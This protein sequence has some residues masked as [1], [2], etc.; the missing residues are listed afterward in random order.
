MM[1][2]INTRFHYVHRS[3]GGEGGVPGR[4]HQEK[5]CRWP[6][7]TVSSEDLAAAVDR[8]RRLIQTYSGA[9]D[10]LYRLE[11]YR[12]QNF[13]RCRYLKI[14]LNRYRYQ[15]FQPIFTD[16]DTDTFSI[17]ILRISTDTDTDT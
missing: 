12:Y 5:Q 1:Y 6:T 9:D 2:R 3:G 11:M 17:V 8:A 16:T 10:H 15:G 4:A 14:Y 13:N 7:F